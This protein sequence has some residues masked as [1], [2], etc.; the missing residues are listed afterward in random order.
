[1]EYGQTCKRYLSFHPAA[2]AAALPYK[3][4]FICTVKGLQSCRRW[5]TCSW[6]ASLQTAITNDYFL[7]SSSGISFFLEVSLASGVHKPHH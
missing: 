2:A 6:P 1:M 5:S 7:K 3:Q 4:A